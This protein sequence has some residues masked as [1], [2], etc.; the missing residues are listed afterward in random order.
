MTLGVAILEFLFWAIE[1]RIA[2]IDNIYPPIKLDL[3]KCDKFKIKYKCDGILSINMI[4]VAPWDASWL[5]A[6]PSRP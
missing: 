6:A 2:S 5:A 1:K 3:L 4:H